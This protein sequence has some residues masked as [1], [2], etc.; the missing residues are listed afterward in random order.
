MK[1]R[2]VTIACVI[3]LST[4]LSQKTMAQQET[5]SEGST[6][7]SK[8]SRPFYIGLFSQ[9]AI[10][11]GTFKEYS[12]ARAG[13]RI[14]AGRSFKNNPAIGGG[15]EFSAIFSGSKKD[16]FRGM[17]VKTSSTLFEIHPF[18][19]W[20]PIKKQTLKPYMDF[21]TGITVAYT[22]TN[23]KIV[24]SVPADT[25]LE[26]VLFGDDTQVET[27]SQKHNTSTNLS[28]SIG[29]GVIIKNLLMVGIRYQHTNPVRYIDKNDVYIEN[30]AIQYDVKHIP[31][32]MIVVTIGIS[33]WGGHK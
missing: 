13:F 25:F 17:E 28:F 15:M 21:S 11:Q 23:S 26:Q 16:V 33:N 2:I 12:N 4:V 3:G 14:E 8:P 30:N 5:L 18:V 7:S 9:L 19:R 31:M 27:V 24:H 10:P 32:D 22:S 29:T 1:T 20:T 6:E